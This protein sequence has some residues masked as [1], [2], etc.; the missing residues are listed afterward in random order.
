MWI[1]PGYYCLNHRVQEK[2][3]PFKAHD[4][5][6][7]GV[8]GSNSGFEPNLINHRIPEHSNSRRTLLVGQYACFIL[9]LW[10]GKTISTICCKQNWR[11]STPVQPRAA[12][13]YKIRR[14]F[15]QRLFQWI[16]SSQLIGKPNLVEWFAISPESWK[17]LAAN[18]DWG[19]LGGENR[20]KE[21]LP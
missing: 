8:D 14:K 21:D 4:Y 1:R 5:T 9:D 19:G 3:C 18:E 13:L 16:K 6:A 10:W 12:A 2:R 11:D 7:T 15:S 17:R 20:N